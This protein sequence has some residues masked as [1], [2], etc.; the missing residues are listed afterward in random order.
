MIL[1]KL[2]PIEYELGAKVSKYKFRLKLGKC[3]G[4]LYIYTK[5]GRSLSREIFKILYILGG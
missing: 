4:I 5:M 3:E 1:H 2:G